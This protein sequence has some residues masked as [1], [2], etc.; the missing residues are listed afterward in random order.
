M[1]R[2]QLFDAIWDDPYDDAPRL[3]YADYL[4]ERGDP[5]GEFIALQCRRSRSG[6]MAT[7]RERKLARR[8]TQRWRDR[9]A[10]MVDRFELWRGFPDTGVVTRPVDQLRPDHPGWVSFRR[11]DVSAQ[12]G[13]VA[14]VA[15]WIRSLRAPALR[16]LRVRES[17]LRYLLIGPPLAQL[18]GVTV[19]RVYTTTLEELFR[20]SSALPGVAQL[21]LEPA[22]PDRLRG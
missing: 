21:E 16:E 17:T 4:M 10:G 15:A 11:L 6:A 3:V 5:E 13:Y 2:Q 18:T 9:I 8:M 20:R 1:D 22:E 19:C 12:G 14:P 7:H